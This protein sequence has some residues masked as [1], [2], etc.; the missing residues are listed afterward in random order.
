MFERLFGPAG[1]DNGE[2]NQ[3]QQK[4]RSIIDFVLGDYNRVSARLGRED[5]QKLGAH[6]AHL[7]S[8][9][10]TL[11]G[12]ASCVGPEIGPPVSA[13]QS[14]N[15]PV[16]GKAQMDMLVTAL[17]CDL[18]RVATMQWICPAKE[19]IYSWLGHNEDHHSLSHRHLHDAA[20]QAK[21][22]Q[23]DT[24]F[25][26]QLAYFID[27]LKAVPEGDGTLFDNTVIFVCS[28]VSHGRIHS[29]ENLPFFLAGSAGGAL[30][31]GRYLANLGGVA[32]NNLLVSL[33]NAMD[34][35]GDTFGDPD[36]CTGPLDGLS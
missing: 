33:M 32:H 3:Y 4:R 5:R 28:E 14:A 22:A 31:T 12:E 10:N 36:F 11:H 34:V 17:K 24:F 29:K 8:I 7:R 13:N 20:A 21:L 27:Q 23:I 30:Q 19:M 18:T 25:N 15:I 26:E 35:P 9:E 6:I 2:L 1:L 16:L